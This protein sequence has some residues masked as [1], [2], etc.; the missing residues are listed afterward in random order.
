MIEKNLMTLYSNDIEYKKSF[1]GTIY[2]NCC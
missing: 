2:A 1:N